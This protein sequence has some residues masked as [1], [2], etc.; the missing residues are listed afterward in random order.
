M[1]L[2]SRLLLALFVVAVSGAITR[3]AAAQRGR[4]TLGDQIVPGY[5]QAEVHDPSSRR[6]ADFLPN[7]GRRFGGLYYSGGNSGYYSSGTGYYGSGPG[8]YGG[9]GYGAF[10][11]TIG[12]VPYYGGYGYGYPYGIGAG[13]PFG[14]SNYSYYFGRPAIYSANELWGPNLQGL[15]NPEG[16]GVN[17]PP[18]QVNVINLPQAALP[19]DKPAGRPKVRVSNPESVS[20]AW[21]WI[22]LGDKYFVKQEFRQANQRYKNASEAAPD[23]PET[24]FRQ[25]QAMVAQGEYT[26]AATA[27]KR[28]LKLEPNMAEAALD[29]AELYGDLKIAKQS[30]LE[31][32]AEAADKQPDSSDLILLVGLELYFDGQ[33][34]RAAAFLEEA[35]RMLQDSDA[36][37]AGIAK[38]LAQPAAEVLPQP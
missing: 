17:P 34:Q 37:L 2:A 12:P 25:G 18:P 26:I 11:G 27:F 31:S 32:L 30:H 4:R 16:L 6:Y 1:S 20:R 5:S 22:N 24:W 29:L 35:A 23:V 19:R 8:Y 7:N 9:P 21:R 33:R 28:G 10:F 13:Y 14:Y 15:W 3:E 38:N 36:H